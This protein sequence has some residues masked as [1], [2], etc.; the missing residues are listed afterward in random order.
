MTTTGDRSFVGRTLDSR[1]RI[2]EHLADG[3]MATVWIAVDARLDRRV[4]V[5]ILRPHLT[6]DPG[7]VKRFRREARAA[8][9]LNDPG[10]VAV[11]DAGDD[12]GT[13]YLVM[14][15]VEG[16]TLREIIRD[17]APLTPRAALDILAGMLGA[18]GA[19]HASGLVH[20]DVKPENVILRTDGVVK[21]ADFGLARAV[22]AQTMTAQ[23]GTLLGT[24]AYLG[25]EQVEFGRAD[26]RTDVYAA[27][28]LLFEMLTGTKAF[29]GEMPIN[30]AYQ[31]V[32][33]SVP[34]LSTRRPD[35]P[36]ELDDLIA[37]ATS[38]EPDDRPADATAYLHEVERVRG[39]LSADVLDAPATGPDATSRYT[40]DRTTAVPLLPG[41]APDGHGGDA[42]GPGSPGAPVD[43]D[44]GPSG[45]ADGARSAEVAGGARSADGAG[46]A[47]IDATA[48][49]AI[50][51]TRPRRRGRLIAG[52]LLALA[53]AA[54]AGF[55]GRWW[56]F[57]HGTGSL[58]TIPTS[59]A[60]AKVSDATAALTSVGLLANNVD[61]FSET[62]PKGL[63]IRADP[64]Q[65]DQVRKD[66][67]VTLVVSKGQ[68]RYAVP[69]VVGLTQEAARAKLNGTNLTVGDV[70]QEYDETIAAG[71][72]IS[73]NPVTGEVKR[74]TPVALVV[75][76][77]RQPIP[78]PDLTGTDV[79][80][81]TNQLKQ[82][83]LT[84]TRGDDAF[85]DTVAK[86]KLISQTPS[87]G[88]LFKGDTVTIV[89]SKGPDVITVPFVIGMRA[90][91]AENLLVARGF[92]VYK[93]TSL[94]TILGL[95]RK[96]S[97]S[98]GQV[99]KRG[100]A[101]TISLV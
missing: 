67:T 42:P 83:G 27:G 11:H 52:I 69:S 23:S 22:T 12:E 28:L 49:V 78:V 48:V 26:A 3:G 85:S 31:H 96:Q 92:T 18:L 80:S 74:D 59:I 61:E 65:G 93:D 90:S 24:V 88:N 100:T 43:G 5:K 62:V 41:E 30:V 20:R 91:S 46:G 34:S 2:V 66:S 54:G 8:A 40:I 21:V 99:V 14:E 56:Y 36:Q 79:D 89:V 53:L 37:T 87:K 98:S 55:G 63:V 97:L 50:T 25:P 82:L 94:G 60:G 38:K 84:V 6:A 9:Q 33:G 13:F 86:D 4:A 72:V 58:R 7:F 81:A 29:D 45:S 77:G 15:L 47:D 101:I 64:P 1:Y 95:V 68:E 73:Q 32:H 71:K 76:K 19:A 70:T 35:L 57:E 17:D 16:R 75:S 51:P 10:V 44:G 39:I